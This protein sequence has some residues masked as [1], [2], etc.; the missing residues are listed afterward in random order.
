MF[1]W[2]A[3]ASLAKTK[4]LEK[5]SDRKLYFKISWLFHAL[6]CALRPDV[7]LFLVL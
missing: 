2:K 7:E 4:E 1:Y 5:H 3:L 6:S